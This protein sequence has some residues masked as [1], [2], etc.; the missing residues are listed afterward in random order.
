MSTTFGSCPG[1]PRVLGE[2]GLGK[3]VFMKQL[4]CARRDGTTPVLRVPACS[5]IDIVTSLGGQIT[6]PS[7]RKRLD[8][9]HLTP[10]AH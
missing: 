3:A 4:V 7:R 1:T 6:H 9:L 8:F 10:T 2:L 5:Y